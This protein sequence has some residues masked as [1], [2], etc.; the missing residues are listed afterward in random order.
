MIYDS[1]EGFTFEERTA[2]VIDVT[3]AEVESPPADGSSL[4]YTLVEIVE[5]N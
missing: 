3:V 4:S 1:I 2:Y 5:E